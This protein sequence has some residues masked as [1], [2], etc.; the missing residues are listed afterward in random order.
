MSECWSDPSVGLGT[1]CQRGNNPAVLNPVESAD[2]N[3]YNV[4]Q[5]MCTGDAE[6]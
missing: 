5:G 2:Q 6:G 3:A 1:T 4:G